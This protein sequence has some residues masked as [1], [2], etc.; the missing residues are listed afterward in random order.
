MGCREKKEAEGIPRPS[1]L[2]AKMERAKSAC[3]IGLA[4]HGSKETDK[5]HGLRFRSATRGAGSKVRRENHGLKKRAGA[6]IRQ[7]K[8]ARKNRNF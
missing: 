1:L 4:Q 6:V 8:K 3:R 5:N 7:G 2:P